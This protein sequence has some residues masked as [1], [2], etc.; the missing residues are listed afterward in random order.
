MTCNQTKNT[1][2]NYRDALHKYCA[3]NDMT[4]DELLMETEEDKEILS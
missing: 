3:Y 4:P 2:K 1:H